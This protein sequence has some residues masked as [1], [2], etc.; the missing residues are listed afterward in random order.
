M[1]D[2]Y[3]VPVDLIDKYPLFEPNQVLT[4][5]HLNVMRDYL[6]Q[7]DRL[8]R[9]R[10]I[11]TG[12]LYGFELLHSQKELRI[13]SGAGITT[14]GYLMT[15]EPS[16]ER[17]FTKYREYDLGDVYYDPFIIPK[18]E[19]PKK[20][21]DKINQIQLWE[22]LPDNAEGDGIES[23]ED[24]AGFLNNKAVILYIEIKAKDLKTC[25]TS[26]CD[27]KGRERMFTLRKLLV[28][29]SELD[30]I[31]K[32]SATEVKPDT[33]FLDEFRM[34]AFHLSSDLPSAI[35]DAYL[36]VCDDQFLDEVGSTL[37][38]TY[39]VYLDFLS[40]PYQGTNPF[41]D[42]GELLK[43]LRN[44]N[45]SNLQYFHDFVLDL[46][47]AY[48]E[49]K[50]VAGCLD[51]DTFTMDND[52]PRH[53]ILGKIVDNRFILA[54]EYRHHFEPPLD[55][56]QLKTNVNKLIWYH[57]KLVIMLHSFGMPDM[58]ESEIRIT[59]SLEKSGL[60]SSR[61]LPFYYR[62]KEP[63]H[64]LFNR[65]NF[66]LHHTGN[67]DSL[68]SYHAGIYSE[69]DAIIHPL[70]Y[71]HQDYPFL[72][73]EGHLGKTRDEAIQKLKDLQRAHDLSFDL[74]TLSIQPG[75]EANP[76]ALKELAS[77]LGYH[78]LQEDYYF[79]RLN[80]IHPVEDLK[81]L[82]R[83]LV[84][85]DFEEVRKWY[86]KSGIEDD[87]DI[88]DRLRLIFNRVNNLITLLPPNLFDFNYGA[89][90]DAYKDTIQDSIDF[91]LIDNGLL[92]EIYYELRYQQEEDGL[93][94]GEGF[95]NQAIKLIFRVFDKLFFTRLL[96]IY[97]AFKSR[98]PV[99]VEGSETTS[100]AFFEFA[101]RNPGLK[102]QAGVNKGG[103]FVMVSTTAEADAKIIADFS[104][105]YR[106]CGGQSITGGGIFDD[107]SFENIAIEPFASPDYA[108]MKVGGEVTLNVLDNDYRA[109]E[110]NQTLELI[111]TRTKNGGR[112]RLVDDGDGKK[113]IDYRQTTNY[114][115][116]DR[117]TYKVIGRGGL[118]DIGTVTIYIRENLLE[119]ID[120]TFET[121]SGQELT[122]DVLKNDS[123]DRTQDVDLSFRSRDA[124]MRNWDADGRY[125]E[126]LTTSKGATVTLVH[127]EERSFFK[128]LP[129]T[130]GEDYFFYRI[131]QGRAKSIGK[132]KVTV[133][134][135][136]EFRAVG[137][138]T[139]GTTGKSIDIQVLDND[140]YDREQEIQ[141]DFAN[142]LVAHERETELEGRS[143]ADIHPL[144]NDEYDPSQPIELDFGPDEEVI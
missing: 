52:F 140:L 110:K 39:E 115:G 107:H 2:S 128:Y 89:F 85:G 53:L 47:L 131:Y 101:K 11:G 44:E 37:R 84:E 106:C 23:L 120:D 130:I 127:T 91:L 126:Q 13:T 7:Q 42:A 58:V 79:H 122:V 74:V 4:N 81:V 25:F 51:F 139:T 14:E 88:E 68:L 77:T 113:R 100:N 135:A 59:P 54:Q 102:H 22:L 29:N 132:V 71:D 138:S 134:E 65:W 56:Q 16:E 31:F 86:K 87:L 19:V 57:Q 49:F 20:D 129:G 69:I 64:P 1:K 76:V 55:Y 21:Q 38:H 125:T 136:T 15:I 12:I 118:T 73:I 8:T 75:D 97:A 24:N 18:N 32:K 103:T 141:L 90:K 28:N 10:L 119:A 99:A 34:K 35:D 98:I 114:V 61:S 27:D 124:V 104:L 121:T 143:P 43:K 66:K 96:Q 62:P 112:I 80:L 133:H 17:T 111:D 5:G 30:G 3:E 67:S 40:K 9:S 142:H 50:E 105:P 45:L 93:P 83:T 123:Y 6:D 109:Y 108:V 94:F 116:I 46:T 60:L 92:E 63:T 33:Q 117:F 26:N 82:F 144:H 78:D 36:Q 70:D 72:R 137:N 95:I 48:R 41:Y